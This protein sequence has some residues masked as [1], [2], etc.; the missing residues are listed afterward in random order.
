M[1]ASSK[2]HVNLNRP[3]YEVVGDQ[4]GRDDEEYQLVFSYK[5]HTVVDGNGLVVAIEMT[6]ANCHDSKSL[7]ILL[8]KPIFSRG[9]H[10]YADKSYSSKSIAML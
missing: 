4:E 10:I 1:R 2:V 6:T 5:L 9:T 8:D 7:L 3:A